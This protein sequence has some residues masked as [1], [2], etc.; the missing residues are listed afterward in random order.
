MV[1]DKKIIKSEDIL[2]VFGLNSSIYSE[3]ISFLKNEINKNQ[4]LLNVK[5]KEWKLKFKNIYGKNL[6]IELFIKHTYYALILKLIALSEVLPFSPDYLKKFN[7]KTAINNLKPFNIIEFE[8]FDWCKVE[9]NLLIKIHNFTKDSKYSRE[10]LFQE[11]Y[12]QIFYP[13]TRHK[14]GEFYTTPKLVKKMVED[15]YEFNSKILDPSCGSG[16]FL[17]EIINSILISKNDIPSKIKA[18]QNIY[19]T[20]INPLATM[21]AKVN[22]LLLL[23]ESFNEESKDVPKIN[24]FLLDALV[25]KIFI[26]PL[27]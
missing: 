13:F 19:G 1:E 14:L 27:I 23:L 9:E 8:I 25:L 17:I 15:F 7:E 24:I 21:T 10:D 4:N 16:I 12:Q 3:T 11:L 20:D 6:K 5:F 18:I 26:V 22:L 2:N